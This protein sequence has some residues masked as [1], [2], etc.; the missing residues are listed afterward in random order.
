MNQQTDNMYIDDRY[1]DEALRKQ[2]EIREHISWFREF[3]TFGTS[4]PEHIRRRYG[5]EEDYQRY[6]KLEIQVHRMPAEPDCRGY[7][8]E[9][10][11]KELCEAGRA[12]GKITLAVEK[13]YESICPAPARDYLEEKYQ[14]LLYLRGMVYRKDYDDPM[15]YKPEILN[16]GIPGTGC[17]ILP[18]DGQEAGCGRAVRQARSTA[19]GTCTEGGTGE[20]RKGKPH[21]QA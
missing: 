1:S 10:R 18:D 17:P 19:V 20:W 7:G 16:K 15:W 4:L 9:Q 3:L 14:E 11:M 5:L 12:K 21:V 8:K 6:K 13:A 2:E